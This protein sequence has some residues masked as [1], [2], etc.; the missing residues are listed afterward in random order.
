MGGRRAYTAPCYSN[1]SASQT[2]PHS[3]S[4]RNAMAT[5]EAA[6]IRSQLALAAGD[7]ADRRGSH[8]GV[9]QGRAP[10]IAR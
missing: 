6:S 2:A 3:T 1:L 10:R 4:D 8:R 7:F 5:T 9:A